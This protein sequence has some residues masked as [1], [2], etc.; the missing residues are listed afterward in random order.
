MSWFGLLPLSQ[1]SQRILLALGQGPSGVSA[2][3][4]ACMHVRHMYTSW[5]AGRLAEKDCNNMDTTQHTVQYSTIPRVTHMHTAKSVPI[6]SCLS[7][8]VTVRE[9]V[10]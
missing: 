3:V 10:G 8:Q 9:H 6:P 5:R 4:Q 1:H 7:F 2:C